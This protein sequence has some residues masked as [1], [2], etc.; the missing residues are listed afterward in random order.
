MKVSSLI[1]LQISRVLLLLDFRENE[2][3]EYIRNIG[4]YEWIE[5]YKVWIEQKQF[6][7]L[8]T[9]SSSIIRCNL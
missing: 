3:S 8:Q 1:I 4:L 7:C 6:L 5:V 9:F 2:W